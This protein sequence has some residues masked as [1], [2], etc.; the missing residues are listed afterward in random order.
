M[1][2]QIWNDV[3]CLQH[4]LSRAA[5]HGACA[6]IGFDQDLPKRALS[7]SHDDTLEYTLT[8][9]LLRVDRR[10]VL[11][12]LFLGGGKRLINQ[13]SLGSGRPRPG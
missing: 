3:R 1:R 8:G 12:D 2:S 4:V 13:I 5:R 7:T 10:P 9:I 6:L 11:F